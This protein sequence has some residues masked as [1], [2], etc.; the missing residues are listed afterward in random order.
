MRTCEAC[1]L[2]FIGDDPTW[3]LLPV[4]NGVRRCVLVNLKRST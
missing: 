2:I 1:G 4:Y 3:D